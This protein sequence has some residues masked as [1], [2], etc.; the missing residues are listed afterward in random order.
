MLESGLSGSVRGVPSNGHPYRDP[1]SFAS[2][3]IGPDRRVN[4]R[5]A[6]FATESI[7]RRKPMRC[8]MAQ[9]ETRAVQQTKEATAPTRAALN[10]RSG[11]N[12]GAR[13]L[14]AWSFRRG[15]ELTSRRAPLIWIKF[16]PRL[17]C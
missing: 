4:V 2:V 13:H 16:S 7:L 8:A 10:A 14:P 3:V 6:P 17:P 1:G 12:R 15:I 5:N 9:Q 11:A